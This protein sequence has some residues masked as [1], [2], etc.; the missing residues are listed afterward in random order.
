M[1]KLIFF[2]LVLLFAISVY[3]VFFHQDKSLKFIPKQADAVVLVDVKKVKR[4]SVFS[5]L[6]NPSEWFKDS[7]MKSMVSSLNNSG[8]KIPD[9][10]QICHLKN[11][12]FTDWSTVLEISDREKLLAFL[13]EKKFISE[14]PNHFEKDDFYLIING[15]YCFAGNSVSAVTNHRFYFENE[16]SPQNQAADAFIN[17]ASASISFLGEKNHN[18]AIEILEDEIEISNT[19]NIKIFKPLIAQLNKK[20][21]LLNVNLDEKNTKNITEFWLNKKFDSLQLAD[22]KMIANLESVNDTIV[23]Y[24]YDDNFNEVEKKSFQKLTQPNYFIS[25][26]SSNPAKTLEFLNKNKWINSE[27]QMIAIPFPPNLLSQNENIFTVKSLRKS[28]II[29][30]NQKGN[31]IFFKNDDLLNN[32]LLNFSPA[33]KKMLSKV[34]S[35]FYGNEGANY[36]MKIKFKKGKMPLILK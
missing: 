15:N 8:L 31:F 7:E 5:L 36:L 35:V 3:Y 28:L 27:N 22:F 33:Q 30:K 2:I 23:T 25:A 19:K 11:Q 34:E 24:E 32:L 21:L 6:T 20:N 26:K 14:I 10:V 18:F 17:G 12:K 13:K 29:D 16:K 1:K 4:E 9:F